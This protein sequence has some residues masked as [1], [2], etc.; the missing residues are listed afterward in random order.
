MDPTDPGIEDLNHDISV[1]IAENKRSLWREKVPL[2]GK[3]PDPMKCWTLLRNLSGKKTFVPP[4]QPVSFKKVSYSGTHDIAQK[5]IKQFVPSPKSDPLT[6]KVLRSLHKGH[7]ID[8]TFTPF[9]EAR[10]LMV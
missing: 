3:R 10:G 8:H 9:T 1:L 7:T 4:N 2:S 5:F 6:R